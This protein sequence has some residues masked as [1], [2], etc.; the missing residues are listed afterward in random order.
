MP[1]T[2]GP[3]QRLAPGRAGVQG[4]VPPGFSAFLYV[5]HC[6]IPRHVHPGRMRLPAESVA[7]RHRDRQP[8]AQPVRRCDDRHP[9]APT[10]RLQPHHRHR[11][12]PPQ[13]SALSD[14]S[15]RRITRNCQRRRWRGTSTATGARERSSATNACTIPPA[16]RWC[17][18]TGFGRHARGRHATLRRRDRGRDRGDAPTRLAHEPE[19]PDP[20]QPTA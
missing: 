6:D 17:A 15:G 4:A 18:D 3:A 9:R 12:I 11:P 10:R 8:P 2:E 19:C 7:A 14:R 20:A 13:C 16:G 1:S 5:V